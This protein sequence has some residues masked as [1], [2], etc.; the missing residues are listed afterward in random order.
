MS[1]T[2]GTA[3][4]AT[5]RRNLRHLPSAEELHAWSLNDAERIG[6]SL[7]F[8]ATIALSFLCLT[9]VFVPL[10]QLTGRLMNSF[11]PLSAYSLNLAGAITGVLGFG[12]LS[13]AWTS[14]FAWLA[15]AAVATVLLCRQQPRLFVTA[16]VLM[17]VSTASTYDPRHTIH[18]SPYQKLEVSRMALPTESREFFA[19]GGYMLESN[20]DYHQK[21]LPLSADYLARHGDDFPDLVKAEAAYRIPYDA[22]PNPTG[23]LVLG[24]GTGNDVASALRNGARFVTAVE[25]DPLILELGRRFH[26]DR[27]YDSSRVEVHT[28]DARSFIQRDYHRYDLIVFGLVDSHTLL[29]G[30]SEVRLDNYLYTRESFEAAKKLLAPDGVLSLAFSIPSDKFWIAYRIH[31]MLREVF[32]QEP[33]CRP[34][35]YDRSLAFVVGVEASALGTEWEECRDALAEAAPVALPNDD[36]P[37][38]YMRNRS[39]PTIYLT[40]IAVAIALSLG[41]LL[42]LVPETKKMQ[43]HFLF[44][45]AAFMLVEVKAITE[46]ALVFG[47]TWLVSSIA[48]LGILVVALSA[49]LFVQRFPLRSVTGP[50]LLLAASL[51][52]GYV[53]PRDVLLSGGPLVGGSIAVLLLS[54]PV[55]FAGLIFS[56][57]LRRQASVEAA[58]GANLFGSMLGGFF[59]YASLVIGIKNLYLFAGLFYALS[60]L[61]ARSALK[62]T[63]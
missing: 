63:I 47:T 16:I 53:F 51:V 14:P 62:R 52:A 9:L 7:L 10:G 18:W 43:G 24:A 32:E 55:F 59:E 44:L 31:Q 1:T 19:D 46:L 36:W 25:I 49:N 2:R 34:T 37:Y 20:Q 35:G 17:G 50:Y 23:V 56:T 27:P 28:G 39:V 3:S 61:F 45:G 22:K 6:Q 11:A 29:S 8:Y 54:L 21:L 30:R 4:S 57:L 15:T 38:L 60:Y 33:A 13:F 26:P 41:L 58:F 12:I 42:F 48:I 5:L 40:V